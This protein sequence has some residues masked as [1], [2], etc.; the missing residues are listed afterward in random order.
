MGQDVSARG[1]SIGE[2]RGTQW[3]P[4]GALPLSGSQGRKGSSEKQRELRR[5]WGDV[6]CREAQHRPANKPLSFATLPQEPLLAPHSSGCSRAQRPAASCVP[7]PSRQLPAKGSD[8]QRLIGAPG[9]ITHPPQPSARH[10]TLPRG[11][12]NR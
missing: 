9:E 10:E 8:T 4:D 2:G 11:A 3:G 6:E 5:E 1:V 7:N 12:R